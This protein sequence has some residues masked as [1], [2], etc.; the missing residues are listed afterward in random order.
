MHALNPFA[1]KTILA[2]FHCT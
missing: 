1:R 2:V